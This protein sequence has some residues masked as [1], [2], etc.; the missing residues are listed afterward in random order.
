[1]MAS[2]DR[3][4]ESAESRPSPV[5]PLPTALYESNGLLFELYDGG[6]P[7]RSFA[8]RWETLKP[9]RVSEKDQGDAHQS[10][11]RSCHEGNTSLPGQPSV[12]ASNTHLKKG[13]K[14]HE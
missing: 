8:I 4:T 12:R 10:P 5:I 7:P 3:E 11:A 13:N 1:M 14:K 6:L 2:R 9:I